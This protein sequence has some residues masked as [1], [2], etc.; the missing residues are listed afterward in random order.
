[1]PIKDPTVYPPYWPQFS[2]YIRFDRA[3]N[4]CEKCGVENGNYKAVYANG[5]DGVKVFI[6]PSERDVSFSGDRLVRLTKI[7]LTV[8][9]LDHAGGVCDCK[10]TT[11]RKCSRPHHVLALCQACHLAM[12]LPKHI[13]NRRQTMTVRNDSRR[14]LFADLPEAIQ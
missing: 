12:D 10:E 1:M 14:P 2:E 6:G 13:E 7:V 8:A 4:H 11:G 9:H 3:R 5:F